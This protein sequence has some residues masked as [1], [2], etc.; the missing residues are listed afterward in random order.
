MIKLTVK[1]I[2]VNRADVFFRQGKYPA[3]GLEVAGV[4]ANGK[5]YA[6]IMDGGAYANEVMVHEECAIE[7]PTQMSF[8]D[9]ASIIEALFTSYYNLVEL[10]RLKKGDDVLV[11]GGA[12]GVGVVAIQLAKLLGAN[13]AATAG[14]PEKLK[15]I[16]ELGATAIDYKSGDFGK[17]KYD[18]ILDIV[19]GSYF[20]TN[21]TALKKQGRLAIISFIGGAKTEA[22]LA[23]LLLKDLAV[24]GSTIR[25]LTLDKKKKIRDAVTPFFAQVKP[26]I[27]KIF[28]F[29]DKEQALDYVEQYRNL[30]KVVINYDVTKA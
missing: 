11:H 4:D 7:I 19:G 8:T 6:A 17:E 1:A 26:V 22:N 9:A 28:P 29:A 18:V 16:S 27:G 25:G 13:V 15:L 5:R 3:Q 21:L 23:P 24:Y 10:C 30:G 12:S 14:K 20:N 2:G